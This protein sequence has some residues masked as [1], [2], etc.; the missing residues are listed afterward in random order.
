[1]ASQ[2][3][4]FAFQSGNPRENLQKTVED[5]FKLAN[6]AEIVGW[7]NNVRPRD[8]QRIKTFAQ[9]LNVKRAEKDQKTV[10]GRTERDGNVFKRDPDSRMVL[11]KYSSF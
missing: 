11:F 4:N 2:L 3:L 9:I 7:M 5:E 6:V 1:M 10:Q 8:K